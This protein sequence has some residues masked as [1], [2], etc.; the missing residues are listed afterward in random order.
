MPQRRRYAITEIGQVRSLA[1][2]VR[3]D[4]VDSV[5]AGGQVTIAELA[6]RLGRP[7]DSLYHHVR[8]LA[9]RRLLTV[10]SGAKGVGRPAALLDVPG[11]PMV[12]QYNSASRAFATAMVRVVGTMLSSAKR[13]FA[14]AFRSGLAQ[15]SGPRRNL[16]AARFQSWLTPAELEE[17]NALLERL[18]VLL[19]RGAGGRKAKSRLHEFTYVLAPVAERGS[20]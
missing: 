7:A 3:Q 19:R 20:H 9:K 12:I 13:S 10:S 16:W 17:V 8:H 5:A 15:P 4:I 2:A 18:G 14:H 11:R 1:S 6:D